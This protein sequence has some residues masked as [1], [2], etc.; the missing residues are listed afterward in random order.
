[1]RIQSYER[2]TVEPSSAGTVQ[3]SGAGTAEQGAAIG[4]NTLARAAEELTVRAQEAQRVTDVMLRTTAFRQ[5]YNQWFAKRSADPSGWRTLGEESTQSMKLLSEE[6]LKDVQDPYARAAIQKDILEFSATASVE[7]QK[8]QFSQQADWSR[9][10]L[11]GYLYKTRTDVAQAPNPVERKRLITSA[12]QAI[13]GAAAAG[14]VSPLESEKMVKSF[15]DG[16]YEDQLQGMVYNDP[17]GVLRAISEGKFDGLSE[18]IKQRIIVNAEKRAES[19]RDQEAVE[20]R[21]RDRIEERLLKRNQ[22][23]NF[24]MM[25]AGATAGQ[26]NRAEAYAA[27][28]SGNIRAEHYKQLWDVIEANEQKGGIGNPVV[29]DSMRMDAY[30]GRLTVGQI[31]ASAQDPAGIN[32]PEI[33]ELLD[34]VNK[35]SAFTTTRDYK[36]AVS[37]LEGQL[38]TLGL[39]MS[40]TTGG[41]G[42][43]D[44][45]GAIAV[46][47]LYVRVQSQGGNAD[48]LVVAQDIATRYA[49]MPLIIKPTPRFPSLQAAEDALRAG[50]IGQ[51]EFD[52]EVELFRRSKQG[53]STP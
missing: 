51:R 47:E 25:Y 22:D 48:P 34:L 13:Q 5:S 32:K 20:A 37:Y 16:T 42:Q 3:M 46:R 30:T 1:M 39:A 53:T 49:K 43:V 45:L 7:A 4:L 8:T 36:E 24:G 31:L 26:M 11:Q 10:A 19:L 2:T 6:A 29:A 50:E 18:D 38:K 33:N 9:G 44:A 12:T 21:R 35:G 23:T 28:Q 41:G 27:L 17:D 40:G 52:S 14:F 15:I